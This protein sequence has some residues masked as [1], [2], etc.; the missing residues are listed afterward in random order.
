MSKSY[1]SPFWQLRE[2]QRS[3]DLLPHPLP[4]LGGI[5]ED[6]VDQIEE[7][8]RLEERFTLPASHLRMVDDITANFETFH[9]DSLLEIAKV[10]P[11]FIDGLRASER[12]LSSAI[13]QGLQL[14]AEITNPIEKLAESL[15][16]IEAC[17]STG[18]IS[19]QLA[20]AALL[21]FEA[22][23]AFV[24][25]QSALLDQAT[26]EVERVN[27]LLILD[28]A[29]GLLDLASQASEL[30]LL[31]GEGTEIE[32]PLISWDVNLFT[33]LSSSMEQY[34]VDDDNFSATEFVDQSCEAQIVE[35]GLKIVRL[36][37]DLNIEAKRD[38]GEEIFKPTNQGLLSCS[39]ISTHIADEEVSF[40][41]V[42]D[43]LY[44]LLYE[45]SGNGKRLTDQAEADTLG[46]LWRLKHLRLGSSHDLDHGRSSK[47]SSNAVKVGDAFKS[48]IGSPVPKSREEWCEAQRALYEHLVEMLEKIWFQKDD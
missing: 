4:D 43:L 34:S 7:I 40:G 13:R 23:D 33:S 26:N 42:V 5:P 44:F 12:N 24:E 41:V 8:R 32:E 2:L 19:E 30:G 25:S 39:R 9:I 48:L 10:D 21:P 38:G 47:S 3:L 37:Y 27:R 11:K 31:M 22:Y 14:H 36:V 17:L 16:P 28:S 6:L 35:L 1:N 20:E 45:G 29:A 46:P 18:L 15:I